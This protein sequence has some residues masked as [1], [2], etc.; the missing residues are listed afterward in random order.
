METS[1]ANTL[2]GIPVQWATWIL[3]IILVK[4][5][6]IFSCSYLDCIF[7]HFKPLLNWFIIV[8]D[9]NNN[10]DTLSC[11]WFENNVENKYVAKEM[12]NS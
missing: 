5:K 11:E 3:S 9:T 7:L 4:E 1:I 12:K 10:N 8:I 6:W 2:L